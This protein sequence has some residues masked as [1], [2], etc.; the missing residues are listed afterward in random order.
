MRARKYFL[1][2]CLFPEKK[3]KILKNAFFFVDDDYHLKKNTTNA[4]QLNFFSP[5]FLPR[6]LVFFL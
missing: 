1:F 5:S 6:R 4:S 3:E 2:Y